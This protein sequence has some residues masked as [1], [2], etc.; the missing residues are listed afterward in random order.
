MATFNEFISE[1]SRS[2]Q[3]GLLAG[4]V[5]VFSVAIGLLLWVN[6]PQMTTLFAGLTERDASEVLSQLE[7]MKVE[8]QISGDGAAILVDEAIADETRIKLDGGGLAV[9]G[10]DGFEL[11]NDAD[12]GMTEFVQKINYQRA[13]QGELSRTI[14]ALEE[15]RYA[16]VHLVLPER[17]LFREPENTAK[18]SITLIKQPGLFLGAAQISGIQQLVASAVDGM[19]ADAVTILDERGVVLSH[20]LSTEDS[21]TRM[22]LS[23]KQEVEQYL[24]GKADLILRQVFG[25]D[26]GV[27]KIDVSLN[28]DTMQMTREIWQSPDDSGRDGLVASSSVQRKFTAEISDSTEASG[29]A[30]AS[31]NEEFEYRINKTVEQVVKG[32]G[33]IEFMSVSVLV[34]LKTSPENVKAVESLIASAVGLRRDR[35]DIIRVL[36][37]SLASPH[38]VVIDS[39][40][41]PPPSIS[42]PVNSVAQTGPSAGT[43]GHSREQEGFFNLT[44]ILWLAGGA[45]GAMCLSLLWPRGTKT[46]PDPLSDE[47]KALLL[48]QVRGWFEEG[49]KK[50]SQ[51]AVSA[52]SP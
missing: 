52:K 37:L 8:Y 31:E 17:G 33:N 39:G 46:S 41:E 12:Y 38:D 35:G 45:L 36:P 1:Q 49:E 47:E 28:R 18:A 51:D 15:V 6:Q 20:G 21:E 30:L 32:E 3:L 10:G 50:P 24:T 26:I 4:L 48:E 7:E 16:R 14:M 9:N 2:Q 34:P 5:V 23:R 27:V 42:T 22:G 43:S 40:L 19:T 29:N 13:L 44:S 11:F 25:A